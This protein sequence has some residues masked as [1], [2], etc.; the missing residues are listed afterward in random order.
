MSLA[1]VYWVAFKGKEK[2][3]CFPLSPRTP[4]EWVPNVYRCA[5]I[6]LG[7]YNCR[8]RDYE[9]LVELGAEIGMKIRERDGNSSDSKVCHHTKSQVVG[10]PQCAS[11]DTIHTLLNKYSYSLLEGIIFTHP[12]PPPTHTHTHPLPNRSLST[13][14]STY[15][16]TSVTTIPLWWSLP[17]VIVNV[18]NIHS[19]GYLWRLLSCILEKKGTEYRIYL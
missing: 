15:K 14:T 11:L 12:P 19:I 7:L 8:R 6:K 4:G 13:Y 9:E 18:F 10:V 5:L 17:P 1:F 3:L 16:F 2:T